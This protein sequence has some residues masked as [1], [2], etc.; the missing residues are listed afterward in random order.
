MNTRALTQE[1]TE[2]VQAWT[3]VALQKM[4]YMAATLFSLRFVDA[5]G[6]G[7]FA[8]DRH[9]RCYID[10]T[11]VV[12][13]G[14]VSGGESLL[15]E[16]M[17]LFGNDAV[18]ADDLG[19]SGGPLAKAWNLAC[20]PAGTLLPGGK[21]I[22]QVATMV[23]PFDGDLVV[24]ESQAGTVEATPEHPFYV[25]RRRHKKGLHPVVM[26]EAEWIEAGDLADGDYVCVPTLTEKRAD[27]KID[28]SGHAMVHASRGKLGERIS[29]R[30]VRSIPLDPDVAWLIGL[31]VAEGSSSPTV[32]FSLSVDEVE[33]AE[34][35]SEI[36]ERIG[37][38]ASFSVNESNHTRSVSLGTTVFGRWLKEQCGDGARSK[39]IPDVILRHADPAIRAAFIEGLVDGDGYRGHRRGGHPN[40]TVATASK[41]LM[42]DLVLLLAQDGIGGHTRTQA[43]R[44]RSIDRAPMPDG[45]LYGVSWN[46]DGPTVSTRTMNGRT[47]AST[48]H[49]WKSDDDGVWYPVKSLSRRP[50]EG[51]VY[52]METPSHTYVVHGMLVHNCDA[53]HNDDLRDGG[54]TIF[55]DG[56][57]FVLPSS[58]GQPDYQTAQA[59]FEH[60]RQ[61]IAK[62]Q[63]QQ[64]QQ[65]QGKPGQQGQPGAGGDQPGQPGQ[66][67]QQPGQ[68]QGGATPGPFKGC[69]SGSGGEAAPCELDPDADLG[70]HAAAATQTEKDRVRIAT[71]T[72]ITEAASKGRGNVPGG[73]VQKAEQVL[74]PSKTPWQRVLGRTLR[75]CVR[76]RIGS[77][78]TSFTRR[79]ARRH[80]ERILTPTGAGSRVVVPGS[81]DPVPTIRVIRDTSGSMSQADL[82]AVTSEVVAIA[83]KLRVRGDDL[84]ITDVDAAVHASKG[85]TG[86]RGMAEVTGRGGT[87]MVVGIEHALA[88]KAKPTAVVVMTDGETGWPKEQTSR[89]P[90]IAVIVHRDAEALAKHVPAWIRTVLVEPSAA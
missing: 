35:I 86:A 59:Y 40:W 12:D 71:A 10:F 74:T 30:T 89:I 49:R 64:A 31:Y 32:R 18:F 36:A 21:P 4:P 58:I 83:K 90:V 72:A 3:A 60:L 47:M 48:Q 57:Q 56:G 22:E 11:A 43:Q 63:Q 78:D 7:T 81:V 61:A 73:L 53:A 19:I 70:G 25:R 1:Q 24:V 17:H 14:P 79:N 50:Y 67:G 20:F 44:P 8:V 75:G 54:C 41:A 5:P 55:A 52:N 82:N 51:L 27:T 6:L 76:S 46:P 84:V 45:V 33:Y 66:A 37:Y 39:H 77:M 38:S 88:L 68:G 16:C 9:H 2:H 34:R 80:N 15:H 28:L 29:N 65:G 69:G 13:E 87:D 23:R 42:H 26:N 85:F 62:K